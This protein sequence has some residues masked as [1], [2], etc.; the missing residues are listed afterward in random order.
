MKNTNKPNFSICVWLGIIAFLLLCGVILFSAYIYKFEPLSMFDTIFHLD[1]SIGWSAL[2]AI[3][4][5]V[6]GVVTI[7]LSINL[8]KAQ[9]K[10]AEIQNLQNKLY[11]EPHILVDS[12]DITSAKCEYTSDRTE[13]KSI[14]NID[15]PFFTNRKDTLDLN[16]IYVLS[17]TFI[18][19]SEAFA[20]LRFN[21]AIIKSD[22][23]IIGEYNMSTFG[24]HKNHIMINKGESKKIGLIISEKFIKKLRCTDIMISCYLDNNYNTTYLDKQSYV[25]L[26]NADERVSFMPKKLS[27]NY[28][29]K[30]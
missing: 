9:E 28:Y 18:N 11:I 13:I 19:T 14:E 24:T 17:I 2:E 20:R 6:I 22:D 3:G 15:Y 12:F 10:Q 4:T 21:E 29:G 8:A 7:I 30:I 16:D 25:L 27:D 1:K 5:I 23:E 26:S